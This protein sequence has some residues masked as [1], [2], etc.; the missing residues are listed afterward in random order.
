MKHR[1]DKERK[2]PPYIGLCRAEFHRGEESERHPGGCI[3]VNE[4]R[5]GAL[6][7]S[8]A[9]RGEIDSRGI[10]HLFLG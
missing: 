4:M 6:T 2:E 3:G 9:R 10:H 5:T 8:A 7:E 1:T